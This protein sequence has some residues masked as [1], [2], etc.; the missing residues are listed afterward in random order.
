MLLV[1]VAAAMHVFW[2][3]LVKRCCDKPSFALLTSIVGVIAISPV[4]LLVRS[5]GIPPMEIESWGYAALSGLFE[6]LYTILLF[7]AYAKGDLSVVY[8]LSRGVAPVFTLIFGGVLLGDTVTLAQGVSVSIVILG[9]CGV[10]LSAAL[11]N[12]SV[13]KESGSL[14]ALCT[15]FMIAGYHLVDRGAMIRSD[16]PDPIV[17]L[18]GMHLFLALFVTLWVVIVNRQWQRVIDEWQTNR[19]DIFTVGVCTPMAYFLIIIALKYGNVTHVAAGRNIGILFSAILGSV[20][21]KEHISQLRAAGAVLIACGVIG[22]VLFS[23]MP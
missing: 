7:Q 22:L 23:R 16:A 18:F 13:F 1:A 4:F 2:N 6:A 14:L 8:P 20:F 17:Y 10:S 15:G 3:T 12:R 5:V 19:R 21:L 9:V 11:Q